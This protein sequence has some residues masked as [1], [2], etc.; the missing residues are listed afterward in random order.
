MAHRPQKGAR[1]QGVTQA[2]ILADFVEN[3]Q[4]LQL[5]QLKISQLFLHFHPNNSLKNCHRLMLV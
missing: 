4:N 5:G 3:L 2:V 1:I